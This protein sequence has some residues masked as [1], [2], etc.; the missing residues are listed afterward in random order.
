VQI[1]D[2]NYRREGAY[3]KKP[4][5]QNVVDD[6][7]ERQKAPKVTLRSRVFRLARSVARPATLK[8]EEGGADG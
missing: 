5:F 6:L 1:D 2:V 7:T 4:D 3:M 8:V